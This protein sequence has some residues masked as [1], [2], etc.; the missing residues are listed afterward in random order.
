MTGCAGFVA[1][2]P[3]QRIGCAAKLGRHGHRETKQRALR[4]VDVPQSAP[5][6]DLQRA[7]AARGRIAAAA[8]ARTPSAF[9]GC[10]SPLCDFIDSPFAWALS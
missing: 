7:L 1:G 3:D 6:L 4:R 2:P 8:A 5:S 10:A 9:L